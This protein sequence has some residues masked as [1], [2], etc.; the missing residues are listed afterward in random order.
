MVF[1]TVCHFRLNELEVGAVAGTTVCKEIVCVGAGLEG[2]FENTSEL[3][4]MKLFQ[5]LT[6]KSVCKLQNMSCL[7]LPERKM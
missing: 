4:V 1:N 6:K 3:K 5:D 2:G 7:N